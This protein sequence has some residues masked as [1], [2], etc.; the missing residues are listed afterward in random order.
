M[1]DADVQTDHS[2][3]I[4]TQGSQ[5]YQPPEGRWT[6]HH[7]SCHREAAPAPI[8]TLMREQFAEQHVNT[9][10]TLVSENV[11]EKCSRACAADNSRY[12]QENQ[13][14]LNEHLVN[15]ALTFG[16]V[17]AGR[18]QVQNAV[19]GER[20]WVP[21]ASSQSSQAISVQ[22]RVQAKRRTV[23]RNAQRQPKQWLSGSFV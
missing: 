22:R 18:H 8:V 2:C 23:M 6:A 1:N 3:F 20:F 14:K 21:C 5:S 12:I 9:T 11:Q 15:C 4:F 10:A 7:C 19:T 13:T 17:P 16:Y